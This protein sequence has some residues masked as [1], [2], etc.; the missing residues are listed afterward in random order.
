MIGDLETAIRTKA[1]TRVAAQVDAVFQSLAQF[2]P[3]GFAALQSGI[4]GQTNGD[5]VRVL[6]ANRVAASTPVAEQQLI[7]KVVA[8]VQA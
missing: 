8:E 4:P 7:D 5:L 6:K 1:R 2:A 3:R